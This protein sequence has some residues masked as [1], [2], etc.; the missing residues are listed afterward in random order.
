VKHA[1]KWCP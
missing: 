1:P